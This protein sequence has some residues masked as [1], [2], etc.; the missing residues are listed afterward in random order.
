[1]LDSNYLDSKTTIYSVNITYYDDNSEFKFIYPEYAEALDKFVQECE[2]KGRL[3]AI[4]GHGEY[5]IELIDTT[6][7]R[8]MRSLF[9]KANLNL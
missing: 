8:I 6:D 5:K 7:K 2:D 3:I 4:L 9:F 1:M